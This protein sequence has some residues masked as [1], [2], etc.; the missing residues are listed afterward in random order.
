[1]SNDLARGRYRITTAS[2]QE[3]RGVS[4][5][6]TEDPAPV[7]VS[8]DG[9][10]PEYTIVPVGDVDNV[11]IILVENKATGEQGDLVY[12]FANGPVDLWHIVSTEAQRVYTIRKKDGFHETDQFLGW[13][14]PDNAET[15]GQVWFIPS[16]TNMGKYL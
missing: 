2:M 10:S 15:A 8:K 12:A 7:I 11:Y 6:K 5:F 16:L 4:I 14:A 9:S 3:Q 13:T 1:M